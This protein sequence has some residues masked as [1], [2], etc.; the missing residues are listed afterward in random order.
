[1]EKL[2]TVSFVSTN[3]ENKSGKEQYKKRGYHK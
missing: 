2:I 1:M 3:G